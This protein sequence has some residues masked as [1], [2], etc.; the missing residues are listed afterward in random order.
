MRGW[1]RDV[2]VVQVQ[3]VDM[4]VVKTVVNPSLRPVRSHPER[5]SRMR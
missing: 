2:V 3:Y 4:V 1:R 5:W